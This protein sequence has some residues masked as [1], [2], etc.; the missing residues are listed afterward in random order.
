MK[1]SFIALLLLLNLGRPA[2]EPDLWGL[3]AKT[4]YVEKLNR[5]YSSY[6]LYPKFSDELKSYNGKEVVLTGF[7]IPLEME[8]SKTV[9][10]SKFPMAECFF[11]GGAGQESIAVAYLKEKPAKRIKTDQIIKVQGIL[12]LNDEDVEELNFILK[13]AK[14]LQ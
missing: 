10:I 4:G 5:Q 14:I 12:T 7:Y 2:L 9:V 1:L 6:F 3:F 11:C 13:N 8:N